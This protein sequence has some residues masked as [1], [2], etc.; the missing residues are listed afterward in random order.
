MLIELEHSYGNA[1]CQGNQNMAHAMLIEKRSIK[2]DWKMFGLGMRFGG[3]VIGF[4]MGWKHS[5]YPYHHTSYHR[6]S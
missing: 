1:F 2:T 4:Q 6:I 5:S 3:E